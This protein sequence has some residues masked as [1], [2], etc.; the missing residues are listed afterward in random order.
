[1]SGYEATWA[2]AG[3]ATVDG[4]EQVDAVLSPLHDSGRPVVVDVLR[5]Q[6]GTPVDGVQIGVGHPERSFVLWI[7]EQGGYAAQAGVGPWG[8]DIEFAHGGEPTAYHP[9]E[10]RITPEAAFALVREVVDTG[11]RPAGVEWY[12]PADDP[13]DGQ[14]VDVGWGSDDDPWE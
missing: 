3:H 14:A 12:A 13:A 7:G 11:R 10:T 8:D 9:E 2:G 1:M 4:P 5:Y 6:D